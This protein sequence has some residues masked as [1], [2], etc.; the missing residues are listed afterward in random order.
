[1][2]DRKEI[3]LHWAAA[4]N[5]VVLGLLAFLPE[6]ARRTPT[7]GPPWSYLLGAVLGVTLAGFH[8][9]MFI[10]CA[11]NDRWTFSR[12]LWLIFLLILP[13]ASAVIYFLFTRSRSFNSRLSVRPP[14]Q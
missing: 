3:V 9:W 8:F 6:S 11:R 4:I 1:M 12:V 5:V 14:L 7:I 10:E 2:I 13:I